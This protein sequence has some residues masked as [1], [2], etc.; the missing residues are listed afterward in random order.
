VKKKKVE[1]DKPLAKH[2]GK[3]KEKPLAGTRNPVV[4]EK[5]KRDDAEEGP[6]LQATDSQQEEPRRKK[7]RKR[8]A[9]EPV[10]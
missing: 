5:R 7:K 8:K 10:E 2:K 6:A 1:S 9:T 4:G 3:E